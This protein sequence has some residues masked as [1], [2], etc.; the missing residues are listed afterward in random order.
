M[1]RE[2]TRVFLDV[3][4]GQRFAQPNPRPMFPN[5]P[6]PARHRAAVAGPARP[7]L[8]GRRHP[9][10][11]GV[12]RRAGHE[13]DALDAAHRGHRRAVPP[14][15]GRADP[16]VPRRVEGRRP[17][18]RRRARRSAAASSRSSTTPTAPTSA[19]SAA[20]RTRSASSTAGTAR[21][22]K[23]YAGEPDQLVK[24]LAEDEAIAAADTL[25]LTIPNQLGVDYNAHLLDSIVRLRRAGARLALG[26]LA[27]G[28]Q[29]GLLLT[30]AL[31]VGHRGRRGGGGLGRP[32][33][34]LGLVPTGSESSPTLPARAA[35]FWTWR[36]SLIAFLTCLS[37]S[38]SEVG[39]RRRCS[40]SRRARGAGPS[41]PSGPTATAGPGRSGSG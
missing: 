30:G 18:A 36:S 9:Q 1:A 3:I 33:L 20:A 2:H 5:P 23:T 41:G 22:G 7:H 8:V 19:P 24:E 16:D 38:A 31:Q 6:G 35:S 25:L 40:G 10:D 4:D 28:E 34:G 26:V 11:R 14:A 29:L 32:R 37:V 17:R 13:P 12:D 15:P 27:L 39:E 21:F